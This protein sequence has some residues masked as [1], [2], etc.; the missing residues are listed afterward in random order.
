MGMIGALALFVLYLG[1]VTLAESWDH[2]LDLFREDAPFVVPIILGF[3]VQVGLFTHLKLG[4]HLPDG[5]RTAGALT[6]TAGG[7]STLAMVACC[8]HHVTDVLPLVGL[9]AAAVFL[10]EYKVWFMAVGLATNLLGILVMLRL[11]RRQRRQALA[12]LEAQEACHP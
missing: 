12:I 10:A 6:G 3:G 8:A 11:L 5:T 9:S 1:I 2:A 7:T 4:L